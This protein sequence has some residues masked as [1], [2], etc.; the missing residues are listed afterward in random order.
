MA[1][2][3]ILGRWGFVNKEDQIVINPNYDSVSDFVNRVAIAYRNGKAGLID[4]EGNTLLPFRY[5]SIFSQ[6]DA[7]VIASAGKK[8]L[9]DRNGHVLIEPRFEELHLLP[10]Q[11]VL[12]K[13]EKYWGTLTRDGLSII[14]MKYDHLVYDERTGNFLAQVRA[15]WQVLSVD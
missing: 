11:Q 4:A 2:V 13:D 14:P 7:L 15:P 6:G 12:A 8:G 3:K 9:A 10:N 1:P 5:D